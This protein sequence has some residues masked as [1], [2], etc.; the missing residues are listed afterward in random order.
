MP[1]KIAS[2]KKKIPSN[3]NGT[4]STAPYVRMSPGHSSP[5]SKRQDGPRDGS[6]GDQ[7]AEDLRPSP[8]QQ[9]RHVI[10]TAKAA[11]LGRE[12][13]GREGDPEAGQNDVEAQRGRHLSTRRNHLAAGCHSQLLHCVHCGT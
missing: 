6:D 5:I 9:H 11:V 7:N 1:V 12:D 3:P 10:G 8:G 2:R 13:D 4:P